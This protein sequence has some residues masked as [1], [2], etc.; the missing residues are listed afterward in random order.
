MD[1]DGWVAERLSN[2]SKVRE[3]DNGGTGIQ[4]PVPDAVLLTS[5]NIASVKTFFFTNSILNYSQKSMLLKIFS[6][7]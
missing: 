1:I 7:K 5:C 6:T 4:T 2:L 3:L